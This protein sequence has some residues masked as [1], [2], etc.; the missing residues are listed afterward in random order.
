MRILIPN[1]RLLLFILTGWLLIIHSNALAS[2]QTKMRIEF[3]GIGNENSCEGTNETVYYVGGMYNIRVVVIPDGKRPS[4]VEYTGIS[5]WSWPKG[6]NIQVGQSQN[7]TDQILFSNSLKEHLHLD[8]VITYMQALDDSNWRASGGQPM[9]LFRFPEYHFSFQVPNE[10]AGSYLCVTAE[11]DHPEYGHLVAQKPTCM[12]ILSPCSDSTQYKMWTSQIWSNFENRRC[13]EAVMLAD[14]FVTLGW[15]DLFGLTWARMAANDIKQYSKAIQYLD[16]CYEANR[17][18]DA[19]KQGNTPLETTEPEQNEYLRIRK[20][21]LEEKS[22][23]EQ[24]QK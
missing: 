18:V 3:S 6:L 16:L 22:K 9:E 10:L 1:S 13:S 19:M 11:W 2:G 8:Y 24:Q 5:D 15:R 12:R 21:I 14:S 7:P 17:T 4:E 23:Y 20:N